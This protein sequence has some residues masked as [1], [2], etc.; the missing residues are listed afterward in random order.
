[1]AQRKV[2]ILDHILG[3]FGLAWAIYPTPVIGDR[4]STAGNLWIK[5]FG[6]MVPPKQIHYGNKEWL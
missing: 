1:M 5:S 4:V 6:A 2:V 3:L